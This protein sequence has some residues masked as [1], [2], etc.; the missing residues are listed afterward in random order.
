MTKKFTKILFAWMTDEQ[1]KAC[2]HKLQ[3]DIPRNFPF[4]ARRRIIRLMQKQGWDGAN[5]ADLDHIRFYKL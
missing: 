3:I 2:A 1:V 5:V 4:V